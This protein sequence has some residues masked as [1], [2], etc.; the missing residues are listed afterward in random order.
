MKLKHYVAP[1]PVGF[2]MDLANRMTG[3][4]CQSQRKGRVSTMAKM[5]DPVCGMVAPTASTLRLEYGGI[6]YHFCSPDCLAKFQAHPEQYVT[7]SA[8]Q[9]APVPREPG[10]AG[11][12]AAPSRVPE[13][14]KVK[15][16]VS[17]GAYTN[18][19]PARLKHMLAAKDF[20]FVNVHIPYEGEIVPTDAFIPYDEVERNRSKFPPD[21]GAKIF[22]YCRSGRMSAI[23]AEKLV[24]LGYANVW[25]L[26]GGMVAWEEAGLPVVIQK[27]R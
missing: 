12:A 14:V 23:A 21:K 1:A 27:P 2:A 13:P 3:W 9:D 18:V 15:V 8:V 6:T 24:Q 22:L 17:G 4:L 11:A 19:T 10:M 16:K 25:N 7:V 5:K 26:Q 20:L